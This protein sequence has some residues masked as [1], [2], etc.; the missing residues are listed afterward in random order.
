MYDNE[1]D[2]NAYDQIDTKIRKMALQ[3]FGFD[4]EKDTSITAYE[5]ACSKYLNDPEVAAL[6]Y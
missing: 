1:T 6:K 4:P 5:I 2:H 3:S